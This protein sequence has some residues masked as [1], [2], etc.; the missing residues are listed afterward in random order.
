LIWSGA[1][2]HFTFMNHYAAKLRDNGRPR[3]I[4]TTPLQF[5]L[6]R[7]AIT[8]YEQTRKVIAHGSVLRAQTLISFRG[9]I[10]RVLLATSWLALMLTVWLAIRRRDTLSFVV[11]A[12]V[13]GTWLPPE[14]FNLVDRRTTYL[15][16][17]VV[18]MPALFVAVA[19]LLAARRVPR[20]VVLVWIGL[21]L[22]DFA[23]LYPFR[24][25]S[26]M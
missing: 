17:M 2:N 4:A 8:Y 23:S 19:R 12:W 16:Y 3:G 14:L 25:L 18:T 21:L 9:E 10:N 15:Y 11:L 22:W 26:G 24:T 1:C 13:L 6:D 20:F 5:W 7:K